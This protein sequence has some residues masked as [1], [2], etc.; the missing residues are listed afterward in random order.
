MRI[1]YKE[2]LPK[3]KR[4]IYFCGFKILSYTK[5][6]KYYKI[7]AKRF[8]GLTE[9]EAKY[10]LEVQ[11]EWAQK[12]KPDIDNPQTFSEKLQWMKLYYHN[13]L[14]TLCADKVKVRDYIKE[15]IGEEYLVP[16]IGVYDSADDIDF[17]TLPDRFVMKVNWGSGQNIIVKDK[18]KLNIKDAKKRLKNWLKPESNH[19]YSGLEWVYKNIPPKIIIEEYLDSINNQA[20]DYKVM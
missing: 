18:S 3:G 4:K 6:D 5:K 20:L 8:K 2:K 12:R 19:Y 17:S 13:P 9:E 15:K 7:Y 10:I 1:F 16:L 11:F 14:Q